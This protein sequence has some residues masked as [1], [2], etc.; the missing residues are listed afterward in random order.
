MKVNKVKHL[1]PLDYLR[2]QIPREQIPREQIPR[3][4]IP[5]IQ[6]GNER[7]QV[8]NLLILRYLAV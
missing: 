6:M 4:Q 5:R 2:E 8:L 3:E 1:F 7:R